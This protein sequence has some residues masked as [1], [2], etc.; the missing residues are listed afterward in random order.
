MW[1]WMVGI[2]G[3]GNSDWYRKGSWTPYAYLGAGVAKRS[4]RK[5]AAEFGSG[6]LVMIGEGIGLDVGA[7]LTCVLNGFGEK[8]KG[9]ELASILDINVALVFRAR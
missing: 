7:E 6:S 3:Y 5:F 8:Y 2:A 4:V 9:R 1:R